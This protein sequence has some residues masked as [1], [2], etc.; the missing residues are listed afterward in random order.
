MDCYFFIRLFILILLIVLSIEDIISKTVS[1]IFLYAINVLQI[2]S[3]I[4]IIDS[5][6]FW[7]K[8][9]FS[10]IIFALYFSNNFFRKYIGE[11]DIIFLC[12]QFASLELNKF[13]IF[14]W[15]Y[16]IFSLI[17]GIILYVRNSDY[18]IPMFPAFLFAEFATLISGG[19]I[20]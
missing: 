8:I 7:I 2:L 1:S 13:I 6:Y 15:T 19:I 10:I 18:H 12:F 20:W 9:I 17:Y 11:A 4:M 3:A 14:W 16:L 5:K